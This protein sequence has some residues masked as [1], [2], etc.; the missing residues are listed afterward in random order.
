MRQVVENL[1]EHA[2]DSELERIASFLEEVNE[3]LAGRVP[4]R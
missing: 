4:A 2:E 3:Q 1:L